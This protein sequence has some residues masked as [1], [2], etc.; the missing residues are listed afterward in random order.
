MAA[1][2]W[3]SGLL[4]RTGEVDEEFL[5]L[6]EATFWSLGNEAVVSGWKLWNV[7][8]IYLWFRLSSQFLSFKEC[9]VFL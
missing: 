7:V 2:Q 6:G 8:L 3:D 1:W 9:E 4:G 5:L